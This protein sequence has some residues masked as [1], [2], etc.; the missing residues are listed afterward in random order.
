MK[1][2]FSDSLFSRNKF[3]IEVSISESSICGSIFASCSAV[4]RR[5][6][7]TAFNLGSPKLY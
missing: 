7:C 6:F 3:Y 1:L 4:I 2:K 5:Q